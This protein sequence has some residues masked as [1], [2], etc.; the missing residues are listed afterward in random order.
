MAKDVEEAPEDVKDPGSTPSAPPDAEPEYVK[1]LRAENA[2]VRTQL[3]A[4]NDTL[5]ATLQQNRSVEGG[6]GGTIGPELRA[7]LI[8][9]GFSPNELGEDGPAALI[10]AGIR[11]VAP[12]FFGYVNELHGTVNERLTLRDMLDDPETYPGAKALQKEIKTLIAERKKAGQPIAPE[13]AYH[14]A[15][16]MNPAKVRAAEEQ[17]RAESASEDFSTTAD[18]GHRASAGA[19]RRSARDE[20]PAS[21]ADLAKMSR[22]ERAKF[23]EKHGDRRI[24]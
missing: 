10:L 24:Q 19:S 15:R 20:G 4:L 8:R 16:S 9:E 6:G 12:T 11:A 23:Y 18:V 22:E 7:A 21:A 5:A 13:A 1:Q 2:D 14:F 3:K 17:S